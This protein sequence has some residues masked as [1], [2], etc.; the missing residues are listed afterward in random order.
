ME[1][2]AV[3]REL[4]KIANLVGLAQVEGLNKGE[5]ARRLNAAGFTNPD[6]AALIGISE[7]SVRAHVSQGKKRAAATEDKAVG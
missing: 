4:R 6:I 2:D 1:S 5:Q 3:A 7:G